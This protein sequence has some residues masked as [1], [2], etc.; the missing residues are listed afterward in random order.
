MCAWYDVNFAP[1]NVR[2]AFD[3][4]PTLEHQS[5]KRDVHYRIII[6]GKLITTFAV[7]GRAYDMH[8]WFNSKLIMLNKV[9][10]N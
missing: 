1:V 4:H 7:N 9:Y 8:S 6:D 3:I 2:I 10:Q 5:L